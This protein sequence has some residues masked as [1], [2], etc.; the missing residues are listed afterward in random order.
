MGFFHGG[1]N[2]GTSPFLKIGYD[3]LPSSNNMSYER[4]YSYVG[5]DF[6]VIPQGS[7][8]RGAVFSIFRDGMEAIEFDMWQVLG[9]WSEYGITYNNRPSVQTTSLLPVAI[10]I[11]SSQP[12][13]SVVLT[14][15]VASVIQGSQ[16][17]YGVFLQGDIC[18]FYSREN[19]ENPG[20]SLVVDFYY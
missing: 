6:A 9:P 16:L 12:G 18:T 5:F 8:L 19:Q 17:P 15:Y 2:F 11:S 20:P 3:D 1:D 14:D 7:E 13:Y 10:N 4:W